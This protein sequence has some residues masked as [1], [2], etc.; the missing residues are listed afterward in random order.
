MVAKFA[1]G[2]PEESK[3]IKTE[4]NEFVFWVKTSDL[5]NQGFKNQAALAKG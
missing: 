2:C 1:S 4:A 5:K 3:E